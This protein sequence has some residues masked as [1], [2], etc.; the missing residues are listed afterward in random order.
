MDVECKFG[1]P[2]SPGFGL[3][4][5]STGFGHGIIGD[6]QLRTLREHLLNVGTVKF[7]AG[8]DALHRRSRINPPA[9]KGP[10]RAL[11][12]TYG[13]ISI[14]LTPNDRSPNL[15][16]HLDIFLALGRGGSVGT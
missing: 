5:A 4:A 1:D 14:E 6:R 16:G 15:K 10:E 13:P 12:I 11:K 2:V 3:R 7:D 8:Q 9:V